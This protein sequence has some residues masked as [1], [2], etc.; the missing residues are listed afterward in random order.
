MMRAVLAISLTLAAGAFAQTSVH[1][2]D[3]RILPAKQL[4][5]DKDTI[6]AT[7][8][9]PAKEQGGKPT[10][11][12]FGF[13]LKDIFKL[14]FPKPSALDTA[15][16][17]IADGK[18]EEALG[19]LEAS[20]KY[21]AGFRDAPGSWWTDLVPLQVEAL[22][23]L[24]RDKEAGEVADQFSRLATDPEVKKFMKAFTAVSLTRKGEHAAALPLYDEAALTTERTD[25]LGL[26]A[27]NKGESLVAL[28][29]A[30]AAKGEPDQ[31]AVRYEQALLS[32]LRIPALYRTQRMFLPQAT[33]GAAQAYLGMK[34]FDRARV[35]VK[36][37]TTLYAATPEGKAAEE[38]GQK[39]EKRAALLAEP[40]A[41]TAATA[42]EKK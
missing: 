22:L 32:F 3:G 35:S 9:I 1:L 11:G 14:D 19:K 36:E 27:V 5:R 30:L 38:L 13:P 16:D 26:I 6:I 7:M 28:A 41:A 29:D 17:L 21:Y 37:L 23:A 8:E 12:D 20:V 4:R 33:Y 34:D 40:A 31:A 2:K 15:P 24:R 42:A 18:A 39:I 10:S 25:V